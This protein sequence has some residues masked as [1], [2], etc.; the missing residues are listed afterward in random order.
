MT[1]IGLQLFAN[2]GNYVRNMERA[3]SVTRSFH[4]VADALARN[5]PKGMGKKMKGLGVVAG[6]AMM[7]GFAL[8]MAGDAM[9]KN[10]LGPML[11]SSAALESTLRETA[12]L[13]GEKFGGDFIKGMKRTIT[14]T[15]IT[16][17]FSPEEIGRAATGMLK[18]GIQKPELAQAMAPISRLA[19]ASF[20]ALDIEKAT[21]LGITGMQKFSDITGTTGERLDK[22]NDLMFTLVSASK[23]SW[24]DMNGF[25]SSLQAA[26]AMLSG[27][28][29]EEI[30][31][32]GGAL[33]TT[34]YQ[35]RFAGNTIASIANNML[36]VIDNSK[37]G[38]EAGKKYQEALKVLSISEKDFVQQTGKNAGKMHSIVDILKS[39]KRASNEALSSGVEAMDVDIAIKKLLGTKKG[40][41]FIKGLDKF[42]IVD[43]TTGKVIRGLDA[44]DQLV[45]KFTDSKGAVLRGV[46]EMRKS[47]EGQQAILDGALGSIQQSLGDGI[48]AGLIGPMKVLV[49][50][51]QAAAR[52][53]AD[54]PLIA[55][56][57]G[58]TL[59]AFTAFIT[60]LGVV[61]GALGSVMLIIGAIASV[62]PLIS[63][64]LGLIFSEL[65]AAIL[66]VVVGIV[67][68]GSAVAAF[69]AK[70][71]M[72]KQLSMFFIKLGTIIEGVQLLFSQGFLMK[73]EG[74]WKKA[75]D[76]GIQDAMVSVYSVMF[77]VVKLWEGIWENP[78]MRTALGRL[79]KAFAVVGQTFGEVLEQFL[80][81]DSMAAVADTEAAKWKAF[82]GAI[83]FVLSLLVHGVMLAVFAI[84]LGIKIIALAVGAVTSQIA[85]LIKIYQKYEVLILP[86]LFLLLMA[87]AAV[88]IGLSVFALAIGG[89]VLAMSAWAGVLIVFW[90]WLILC[91]VAL[92]SLVVG[93]GLALL[94]LILWPI[95]LLAVMAY[96]SE[97]IKNLFEGM[98]NFVMAIINRVVSFMRS[99]MPGIDN[100]AKHIKQEGTAAAM[101]LAGATPAAAME[102]GKSAVGRINKI[103]VMKHAQQLGKDARDIVS[104]GAKLDIGN[105]IIK[106]VMGEEDAAAEMKDRILPWLRDVIE[107][108]ARDR[109]EG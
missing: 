108:E 44:I 6:G 102:H 99:V 51:A 5:A 2:T 14:E 81:G 32:L 66:L 40:V 105:I 54:N 49:K 104:A 56:G 65:G 22:V 107:Q 4:G 57:I 97:E 11:A 21:G 38:T 101:T 100:T 34:G 48:R 80:P 23:M 20:G 12:A 73:D 86:V 47:F 8:A 50:A 85:E 71:G 35:A 43:A 109:Y 37:K 103:Q 78:T 18:M 72:V 16:S 83:G 76:L 7:G 30:L 45:T 27:T 53:L 33:R 29:A 93:F 52:V 9:A 88:A 75:G 17:V 55:K 15:A 41:S 13:T 10:L 28:S 25:F 68:I 26:P 77:R 42:S 60:V 19:E 36:S 64:G 98:A 31:A 84:A 96:F 91:I 89:Y 79:N 67:A 63:A 94:A 106:S 74:P 82:G 61:V 1:P 92:A 24:G 39:V 95:T 70:S 58:I 62:G 59:A 46:S 3:V 90:G 69:A 87:I